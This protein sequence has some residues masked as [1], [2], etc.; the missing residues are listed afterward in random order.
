[1]QDLYIIQDPCT[2]TRNA[3]GVQERT[4]SSDDGEVLWHGKLWRWDHKKSCWHQAYSFSHC[5]GLN[6]ETTSGVWAHDWNSR[7]KEAQDRCETPTIRAALAAIAS[8]PPDI[9]EL[10]PDAELRLLDA[11]V[12]LGQPKA[13]AKLAERCGDR[14]PLRLWRAT[15]LLEIDMDMTDDDYDPFLG[16]LINP[17]V[18]HAAACA[19]IDLSE[20]RFCDLSLLKV[21]VNE[22]DLVG[23]QF[24]FPGAPGRTTFG[25][26]FELAILGGPDEEI[27]RAMVKAGARPDSF[28]R[29]TSAMWV[30]LQFAAERDF[31]SLQ[32]A[33]AL[34]VNVG[35]ARITG[36]DYIM[37]HDELGPHEGC[38][39][40]SLG[41]LDFAALFGELSCV[42]RLVRSG[43]DI[44]PDGTRHIRRLLLDGLR[45]DDACVHCQRHGCVLSDRDKLEERFDKR[46]VQTV[47]ATAFRFN[48]VEFAVPL[49][50]VAGWWS[51]RD[52]RILVKH[53]LLLGYVLRF[54]GSVLSELG[55]EFLSGEVLGR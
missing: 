42:A 11:A 1:M 2:K 43:F 7:L 41:A 35:N 34:G 29:F 51:R 28:G 13:A 46:Q 15:D 52:G 45:N 17:D 21:D 48:L 16:K 22:S 26:V 27:P 9:V 47:L 39:C 3:R 18:V 55:F 10:S 5:F 4:W 49:L 23:D 53:P 40:G 6:T 32:R 37:N 8:G 50:Q 31:G 30:L 44:T 36:A 14:R 19:G 12:L 38:Y 24:S 25:T 33:L 54:S 20:L